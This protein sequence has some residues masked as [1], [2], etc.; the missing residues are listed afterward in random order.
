MKKKLDCIMLI[1]DDFATNLYH[2]LVIAESDCTVNIVVKDS[3][4]E[5]LEYLQQPFNDE[6]PK[7]N[8]IFLDINMPRMNGW[9][10]LEC[11]K[12]LPVGQQADNVIVML[13]TSS[14]PDDLQRATQ[15]PYV[16]DYR[17]K[18]LSVLMLEEIMEKYFVAPAVA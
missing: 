8:L 6:N 9:E 7:P 1:D 13:S 15:S 16:K 17:S 14:N 5:A 2:K 11:Y 12:D 3:G 4:E 18:P 10:F